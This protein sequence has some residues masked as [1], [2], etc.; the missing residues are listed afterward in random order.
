MVGELVMERFRLLERIGSGA[1]GTVYRAFDERLQRFVAVKEVEVADPERAHREA[2]AAARLNHPG[3]VTLYEFG[4]DRGRALLVSELV[5]GQTVAELV[6]AGQLSDRDVGEIGTDVAD[7][8][9]HAHARGVVH[10]DVKPQNVIVRAEEGAGNRAKLLDF[11]IASVRGYPTLTASGEVIG[12]LAYMAPE[13]ADGSGAVA[14]SD[15]YSLGLTLY[16]CWAGENPVCA[17]TPAETAQR[18]GGVL[19]GLRDHRPDLPA[20][21]AD[22][23]DACLDPTPGFRPAP[24]ALRA[25]LERNLD[26]LDE[27]HSVPSPHASGDAA[28]PARPPGLAGAA[29]LASVALAPAL[30]VASSGAAY[31][32]G[33]G[34]LARRAVSRFV[35]GVIGWWAIAIA[36]VALNLAPHLDV[37][38]PVGPVR[39]WDQALDWLAAVL[40]SPDALLGAAAFGCGALVMGWI[41]RAS[42]V[43]LALLGA[44]LWA[45]ALA[46]AVRPIGD[47]SLGARPLVIAAAA[48]LAVVLS[49]R[50]RRRPS[51]TPEYAAPGVR[52]PVRADHREVARAA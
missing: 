50:S 34:A 14:E 32:A 41:L 36:S 44:L 18:I 35:F 2:R 51:A 9:A 49:Y 43:A 25:A 47:G 37:A 4:T 31:P 11:G 12:T 8:L 23:V 6:R 24:E 17:E 27:C 30:A 22:V 39:S 21:L 52:T 40:L 33:A 3:I 16:E 15:V 29:L 45:A 1:M 46:A 28:E 19:P 42:H 10:R 38:L 48:L 7:A 26:R 13:Q 5:A 20:S